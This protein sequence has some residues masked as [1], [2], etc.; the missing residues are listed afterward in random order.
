[1]AHSRHTNSHRLAFG[2]VATEDQKKSMA[3]TCFLL[4]LD[5]LVPECKAELV[6]IF[7]EHR[8]HIHDPD[9]LLNQL[10]VPREALAL[11]PAPWPW[12]PLVSASLAW[13][14]K[15]RL[16]WPWVPK[17]VAGSLGMWAHS[18]HREWAYPA[19]GGVALI[20][21]AER[22]RIRDRQHPYD[23]DPQF[24]RA[25]S[26]KR[27]TKLQRVRDHVDQL[28]ALAVERGG[29]KDGLWVQYPEHWEWIVYHQVLAQSYRKIANAYDRS[30]ESIRHEIQE[31]KRL[32][33]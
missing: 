7:D 22:I 6:S 24:H 28:V 15:Y 17:V 23:F 25:D 20:Q 2:E 19:S 13:M 9:E 4:A 18:K 33:S 31:K 32:L 16:N 5:Q 21:P 1:V 12:L 29:T 27:S 3:R 8:E 11:S 26:A 14:R 10:H 30:P